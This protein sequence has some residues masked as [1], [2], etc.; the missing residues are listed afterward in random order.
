[1][2]LFLEGHLLV[3]LSAKFTIVGF[4]SKLAVREFTCN[5]LTMHAIHP[6][7]ITQVVTP[8]QRNIK[9]SIHVVAVESANGAPKLGR[10]GS[11]LLQEFCSNP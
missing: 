10:I 8:K 4:L 3:D 5:N 9:K 7:Y 1:M 2:C 6:G 11:A